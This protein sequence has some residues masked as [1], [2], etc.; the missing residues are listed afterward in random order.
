MSRQDTVDSIQER[1]KPKIKVSIIIPTHGQFQYLDMCLRSTY[2]HTFKKSDSGQLTA[3]REK[4]YELII[5]DNGSRLPLSEADQM[6]EHLWAFNSPRG[7]ANIRII[8]NEKNE[9][10]AR[11]NNQGTAIAEGEFLV[12]MNNDVIVGPGWLEGMLKTYHHNPLTGIVG[13][14]SDN[15]SGRQ[16]V[17]DAVAMRTPF[18]MIGA[19]VVT[20]CA[21]VDRERMNEI[22]LWDESFP[23]GLFTDDDLSL[24]FTQAGYKNVIAPVFVMH[25]GSR[26]LMQNETKY[27][28]DMQKAKSLFEDKWREKIVGSI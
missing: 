6:H 16:C 24:R 18:Y 23:A 26:T 2:L 11:A 20:H 4:D 27:R 1:E 7:P 22:G 25:F 9:G 19:R 14:Y 5:I 28:E 3:Y 13:V 12:F 17:F 15:V 10:Y 8:R 21:L